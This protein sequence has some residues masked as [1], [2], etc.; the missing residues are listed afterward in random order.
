MKN[1]TTNATS[2]LILAVSLGVT[3]SAALAADATDHSAHHP[4]GAASALS[5]TAPK[6]KAPIA[7]TPAANVAP[8]TAMGMMNAKMKTMHDMHEKFMAAKSPEERVAL[9]PEHMKSMQEAMSMMGGMGT[10][11]G[12][13]M[14]GGMQDKS[15]AEMATSQQMMEKRMEM[16]ESMMQMMLDRMPSV[17]ATK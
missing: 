11:G 2:R 9:M 5:T 1:I 8:S 17:P 14:M 16:M 7:N 6:V 12:M 13:G 15:P 3:G 10:K 4:E